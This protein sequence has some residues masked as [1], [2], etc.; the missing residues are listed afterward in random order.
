MSD[1]Y[2]PPYTV[3]P[4]IL[5]LITE[6]CECIGRYFPESEAA[7]KPL[8]RWGNRIRTIHA[9]LSIENNT[10][11]L[12]Q[13]TAV[14]DGKRVLGL[15]REI[16]EVRNAFSA[17]EC[18]ERW[19]PTDL[20]DLLEAHKILMF[21][22]ADLPGTFRSSGVGIFQGNQIAHIAPPANRVH[23]LIHDLLNWLKNTKEHPLI[24]SC[25]FHY[26][27][28]FIHPFSDGNGRLGRLWQT[29]ILSRWKNFFAYI[30]VESIIYDR[31]EE[32][33]HFLGESDHRGQS[34][35]FIEFML[36]A[37]KDSIRKFT[38]SDQ[39]TD[40]VTDQ[41][42]RLLMLLK[43]GSSSAK[44]LMKGLGLYH[45]PTFRKNYLDS[46]L[47]SE[48]IER[49]QPDSPRSPTQRYRI[50]EKGKTFLETKKMI[51]IEK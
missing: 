17:Y 28:E 18:S 44:D 41:V 19:D 10:L 7:S 42:I 38:D 40:Q 16:Q 26:E 22:L 39:V 13:V 20:N 29:L 11:T 5:N 43:D 48:L 6:I 36:K 14:L 33:Y 46:A 1:S 2:Q 25:V 27:F 49:T 23:F 4:N 9:S 37:I 24:T 50:T 3:T 31:Q 32:Y 12:E 47:N 45:R 34:T 30:P 35:F 15:P 8:L 21:G 51:R